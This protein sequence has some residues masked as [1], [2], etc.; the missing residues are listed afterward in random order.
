[1]VSESSLLVDQAKLKIVGSGFDQ[2]F[3]ST[4]SCGLSITLAWE[5][6]SLSESAV[7]RQNESEVMAEK[8]T[9]SEHDSE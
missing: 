7:V 8:L 3:G 6:G 2:C 4:L 5:L 1:M 9:K